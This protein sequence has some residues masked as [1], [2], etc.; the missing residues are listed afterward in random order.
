MQS[1]PHGYSFVPH[2]LA[3]LAAALITGLLSAH[4]ISIP[5]MPLLGCAGG[6]SGL[7]LWAVRK[8]NAALASSFIMLATLLAGSMLETIAQRN[9]PANQLRSLLEAGIIAVG[10]PVELTGVLERSPE[11]A[12]ESLYLTL[13]VEKLGSRQIER[14]TSGVVKLM[15]PVRDQ[16]FRGE[17]EALELRYGARIR[18]MTALGSAD[19]YRNPGVASFTE[20]L[21]RKGYDATGVIKS[22]LLIERL[23]DERVFLPLAWL[24]QWRQQVEA[25]M[26]ARFS[27]E[28]AGVLDA[29]LLGNHYH[30]SRATAERFREGGTFHV[31]VISGLHIS[32]IGG[33][34]FLIARRVTK[35]KVWQF[36]LS[37]L[38]LW[39]YAIAVGAQASVVRAALMFT[40]VT[41]AP[42]VSRRAQSL[43]ALGG[44]ALFL[45]VWR[46][47]ELFDP[48]FQLTFLSVLVLVAIAWPLLQKM[49]AIGA[50]QP[51]RETPYPPS[52]ARWLRTLS[53]TLFWSE[54]KWRQ[55]LAQANYS[56]KLFKTP[57][58]AQLERWR[59]QRPL[60]YAAGAVVVSASV[61]LGLLP[62]LILYFHR[63]SLAALVL[64]IGVG[65]L[66]ALLGMVAL[67]ALVIGHIS[68]LAAAPL[69][70]FANA[71]DWVMVHSV[72]LFARAGLASL[73]L[74]EYTGLAAL[75]YPS[76]YVPLVL[77]TV[78]LTRWNPLRS[79]SPP[80]GSGNQRKLRAV[81]L[82][83]ALQLLL[84]VLIVVHPLS[85]GRPDGRLSVDFLDV[86]Q[87]DAALVTMPDGKTLLIDGGGRPSFP[88]GKLNSVVDPGA[89][90]DEDNQQTFE[91]DTRSIGEA[92]VSE[93]LWWRGLDHVDYILA[94][95]ADA[96][97]IDGLNDVARN[98]K[99]R[100][101]LVARTPP[102]DPE[103]QKFAA[104]L[105]A[106]GLRV[107]V[108]GA[109]DV[110]HFGSVT[111]TVYWP[112]PTADSN[113]ASRNNDS[114]VL[115]LQFGQRT[116][117]MTGDVEKQGEAA[118]LTATSDLRTD[119]VKVPHHGSNTSSTE[120]FV[121]VM[122][123]QFAVISVG[124]TSIFGHPRKEVVERWRAGGAAVMTT[125][126]R[127]TI[128]IS[129]DGSDLRV[130]S[131]VQ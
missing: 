86:G 36:A 11:S 94:T 85:A 9:P 72:D 17:Y 15:A 54:R 45:L 115:R 81:R 109:G 90:S 126:R 83:A 53:E 103:Y 34:V 93:Y 65:L 24:Y 49:E 58:A 75:V 38:V 121:A 40:I 102:D 91:R 66:M 14:D 125:G 71:V 21:E 3:L 111:A 16:A 52:C 112:L 29:A 105:R 10:D 82:V 76:Y 43:N 100:A 74:P 110:L 50:W 70:T 63:L 64:N 51:S 41:L 62:L 99:V 25:E 47:G 44:A 127:G 106:R 114:V 119:V 124:L 98:F 60:R 35:R 1:A 123:P 28:T 92:V 88:G 129:T 18:V 12:P 95:H 84:L 120:T 2:P 79:P 56:C 13:R 39:A 30:L 69:V 59:L 116:I 6:V 97:H 107:N 46:P 37:T 8:G 23:D 4:F 128:T 96:D 57:L 118:I 68:P 55:E 113:A 89:R 104:T 78:A 33:L 67:A 108:I 7:S 61:Q 80:A 48:S 42:V 130:A 73:R 22:P 87:G 20:Y 5:L 32:F 26:K 19:N 77:L 122:D 31:L 117:L 27:A 101:A 131:F